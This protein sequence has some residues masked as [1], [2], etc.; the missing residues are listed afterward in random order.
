MEEFIREFNFEENELESIQSIKLLEYGKVI[1][2]YT[3]TNKYKEENNLYYKNRILRINNNCKNENL[4]F[5][6][7]A[8]IKK[9]V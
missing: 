2:E 4:K 9:E 5:Q 8:N 6:S 1:I 7:Y 3:I